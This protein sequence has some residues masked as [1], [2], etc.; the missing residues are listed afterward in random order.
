[1]NGTDYQSAVDEEQDTAASQPDLVHQS[2]SDQK[3]YVSASAMKHTSPHAFTIDTQWISG[4]H[5]ILF[6]GT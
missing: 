6:T 3:L 5:L 4:M 1:M 2:V